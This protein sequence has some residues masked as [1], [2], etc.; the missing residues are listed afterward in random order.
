MISIGVLALSI[1]TEK[2]HHS[3][4]SSLLLF[5]IA[6][7][8]DA[9]AELLLIALLLFLNAQWFDS[10]PHKCCAGCG[11]L[12]FRPAP[13]IFI[14]SSVWLCPGYFRRTRFRPKRLKLQLLSGAQVCGLCPL[15]ALEGILET[16]FVCDPAQALS[17]PFP[18]CFDPFPL[19][20]PVFPTFT[21]NFEI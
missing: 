3:K 17:E 12:D 14:F 13:R 18:L 19:Y 5:L 10:H 6:L 8:L 4:D 15:P 9:C 11:C 20:L 1:F 16:F 7:C 21:N 2:F